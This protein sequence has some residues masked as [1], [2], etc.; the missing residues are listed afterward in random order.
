MNAE[1]IIEQSIKTAQE[2]GVRIIR[3]PL[4]I[5]ENKKVIGCDCSGAVLVAYGKAQDHINGFPEGWLAELCVDILGKDTYWWWRYSHG[6]NQGR[7]LE[8]YKEDKGKRIYFDDDVSADGA[9]LAK[10]L[11]LY[12]R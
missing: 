11:G 8:L 4:F 3:G 1:Q 7:T 2:M 6:F 9:R 5:F 10:K 12:K